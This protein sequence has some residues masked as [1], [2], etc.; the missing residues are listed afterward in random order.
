M[1]HGTLHQG[2]KVYSAGYPL[3]NAELAGIMIHGRGATAQDILSLAD[4]IQPPASD[5]LP[6]IS[7]LAP[8]AANFTWYP[9]RFTA[10]LE[11]NEPWLSS[12]LDAIGSLFRQVN[13]AGVPSERIFLLGFSQ[14]AC[15]ALEWAARNARRYAGLFGLSG[16]LIGPDGIERNYSGSL[17]G[18]P[19]FLGC[20]DSDPHIP[21]GRVLETAQ[22][23]TELGGEVETR[24]YPNMGHFVSRDEIRII[25]GMIRRVRDG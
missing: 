10:P 1:N 12:A 22:I 24:L 16:G 15:L 3:E 7:F 19:V 5:D 17:E 9:Q 21:K 23:L 18:T 11:E 14:G 20:S 13:T 2:Q 25:Q 8:Q 4:E 6:K